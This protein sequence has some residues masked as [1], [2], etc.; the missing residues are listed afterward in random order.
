MVGQSN[1]LMNWLIWILCRESD[2]LSVCQ[3]IGG[4]SGSSQP[5]AHNAET[6]NKL[7]DVVVVVVV[8]GQLDTDKEM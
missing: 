4:R 1:L 5:V 7:L 2:L 3:P 6:D 8:V